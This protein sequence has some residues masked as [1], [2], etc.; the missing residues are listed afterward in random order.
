MLSDIAP[1]RKTKEV[2]KMKLSNISFVAHVAPSVL[3]VPIAG[4][5]NFESTLGAIQSKL[6]NTILPLCAVLGLVFAAFSFFTG[7]RNAS[8]ENALCPYVAM[9][10]AG[11]GLCSDMTAGTR[12]L[13]ADGQKAIVRR[14][15]QFAAPRSC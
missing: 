7:N 13:R 4:Y 10:A 3:L 15:P 1:Q 14:P 2:S 6:I 11:D 5:C 9:T 12:C 8:F